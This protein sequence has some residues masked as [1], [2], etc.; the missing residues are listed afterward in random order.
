MPI[1]ERN[2]Y[3]DYIFGST[4]YKTSA[5]MKSKQTTEWKG[6]RGRAVETKILYDNTI[7]IVAAW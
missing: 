3:F 4:H 7:Y 1:L 5:S 6:V 2:F